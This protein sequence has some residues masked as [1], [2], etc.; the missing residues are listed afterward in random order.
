MMRVR[1]VY[2]SRK[3]NIFVVFNFLSIH[4]SPDLLQSNALNLHRHTL[5]QLVNSDTATSRLVG[6][7]LLVG[8]VHLGEVGHVR[9]E[10]L[11]NPLTNE[12]RVAALLGKRYE[13][14]R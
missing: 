2:F 12:P 6:E 3:S 5:G 4:T 9:E 8:G 10:D 7:E 14:I 11:A 1:F 13:N